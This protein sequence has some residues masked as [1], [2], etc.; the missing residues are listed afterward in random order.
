MYF[1]SL[2]ILLKL[3]NSNVE[4]LNAWDKVGCKS[5]KEFIFEKR[6]ET[7]VETRLCFKALAPLL[8]ERAG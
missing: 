7:N 1:N 3:V 8:M 4:N 6:I 5:V 2:T